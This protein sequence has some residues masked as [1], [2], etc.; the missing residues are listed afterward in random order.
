M[1]GLLEGKGLHW[2]RRLSSRRTA[3][4]GRRHGPQRWPSDPDGARSLPTHC[5]RPDDGG[6]RSWAAQFWL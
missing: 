4:Y 3:G 2:I 6:S 5:G 1:Q